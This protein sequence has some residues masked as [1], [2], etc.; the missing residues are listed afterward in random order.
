M[1]LRRQL[2]SVMMLDQKNR[3]LLMVA[4]MD[5]MSRDSIGNLLNIPGADVQL[6]LWELQNKIGAANIIFIEQVIKKNGYPGKTLVGT[7]T[8]EVAWH[9]IQHS[10]K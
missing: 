8:N 2:D 1:L 10:G 3:E 9:V 5:S 6:Y 4:D 7:P